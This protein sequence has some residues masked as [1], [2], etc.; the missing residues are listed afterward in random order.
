MNTEPTEDPSQRY[1]IIDALRGFAVLGIL[2]INI[3]A[4]GQPAI[5]HAFADIHPDSTPLGVTLWYYAD[6]IFAGKCYPILSL[7]FGVSL[8]LLAD[9]CERSSLCSYRVLTQRNCGLMLLGVIHGALFWNGDI[10]LGYGIFG[11]FCLWLVKLPGKILLLVTACLWAIMLALAVLVC[12]L[13]ILSSFSPEDPADPVYLVWMIEKVESLYMSG[14]LSK[15][16]L[17][18][19]IE[20][21]VTIPL[22]FLLA[23]I[24]ITYMVTGMALAKEKFWEWPQL[25]TKSFTR[26]S[27]SIGG[28]VTILLAGFIGSLLW[29]IG[30]KHEEHVIQGAAQAA[31]IILSSP[32]HPLGY[33]ACLM[34]L[35]L[36]PAFRML[37]CWLPIVGRLSLSIYLLQTVIAWLIFMPWGLGLYGKTGT[38]EQFTICLL[39]WPILVLLAAAW[40]ALFGPHTHGPAE[41]ILRRITYFAVSSK[42]SES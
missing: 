20:W 10:L 31:G 27:L 15:I 29:T 2:A 13:Y 23:P 34:L 37:F 36:I 8:A 24:F 14:D 18:R 30:Q 4:F 5:L 21:V 1:D 3:Q 16:Q 41:W 22:T 17:A 28:S 26:L 19:L 38:T 7:L 33:I 42:K 12:L 35:W 39:I 25:A 32:W 40:T 9:K 6:I 11:L